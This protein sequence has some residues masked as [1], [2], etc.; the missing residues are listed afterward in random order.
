MARIKKLNV[1]SF[2]KFLAVLGALIGL[3]AGIL[4]SFG[5]LIVDALVSIGWVST[6][7]TPGLSYGSVLAFG[8]L[9]GMPVI[10]AVF[11]FILGIVGA[12]LYN[13]FVGRWFGGVELEFER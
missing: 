12:L 10:F 6:T 7:E 4:Y 13:L 11:G 2:A 3:L 1:L 9:I 5:G 8:A